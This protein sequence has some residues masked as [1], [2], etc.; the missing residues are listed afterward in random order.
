MFWQSARPMIADVQI[1]RKGK[2][3]RRRCLAHIDPV[4][5]MYKCA[6]RNDKKGRDFLSLTTII[7]GRTGVWSWKVYAWCLRTDMGLQTLTRESKRPA[8]EVSYEDP[9]ELVPD[10]TLQMGTSKYHK[11]NGKSTNFTVHVS[12]SIFVFF[13]FPLHPAPI[14]KFSGLFFFNPNVD[15]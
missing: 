12:P 4:Q 5:K 9:I 15:G 10:N 6:P 1:R 2:I 7:H 14:Q 3:E 13:N 11:T 8:K